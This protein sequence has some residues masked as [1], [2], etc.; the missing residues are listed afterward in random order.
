MTTSRPIRIGV[1][2]A[3]G[4]MGRF[5]AAAAAAAG[6]LEVVACIVRDGSRQVGKKISELV[7]RVDADVRLAPLGESSLEGM[8]VLIDFS[9]PDAIE[10][11]V[12]AAAKGSFGLVIG[13]TGISGEQRE[14]VADVAK[15]V[16]VLIAANTSIGINLLH[17]LVKEA[18]KALPH[19]FD[20]EIVEAHHRGKVDSPSG[21]A[22][23]L[24]ESVCEAKG[25]R[26]AD[27]AVYGRSP[28]KQG[29]RSETEVGFSCIRGGDIVGEHTV[30]FI[31][32]G[33]RIELTHK[34]V[35]R[36][37]FA[38]GALQAARFVHAAP[39]GLYGMD[40]VLDGVVD[41]QANNV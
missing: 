26:L 41:P 39:P 32:D 12:A 5:L 38:Q 9:V 31:A 20:V 15:S 25:L 34:S 24:G 36:A 8:D 23:A 29:K 14:R 22:L 33:E 16:P 28:D 11:H 21:T 7:P 10:A 4:R 35:T 3:N 18:C 6:D 37:V 27:A 40:D 30:M 1:A 17:R 19:G 13:T 2:G